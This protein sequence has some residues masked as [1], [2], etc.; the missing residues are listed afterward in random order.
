M[1]AHEPHRKYSKSEQNI[2][3]LKVSTSFKMFFLMNV[4]YV[5]MNKIHLK[6]LIFISWKYRQKINVR[7]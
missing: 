5:D 7:S 4:G 6:S 2:K 1:D 3:L